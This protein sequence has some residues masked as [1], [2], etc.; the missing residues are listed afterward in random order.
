MADD[1]GAGDN[2]LVCF[3]A[4]KTRPTGERELILSATSQFGHSRG[5]VKLTGGGGRRVVAVAV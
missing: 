3:E 5:R 1:S 4:E 2:V